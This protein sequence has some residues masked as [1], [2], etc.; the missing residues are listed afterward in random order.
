MARKTAKSAEDYIV[1]LLMNDLQGRML[2]MPPPR[3]KYREIMLVYGHHA[4]LERMFGLAEELNRYGGVTMPDLPGFGGMESFYKIKE[5]PTLD[6]LADYLAAFVKL[7]YR[8]RRLTVVAMSFGFMVVTRM[9]Q[10]YPE[11]AKRVDLLISIVGSVH[12]G[13]I[14]FRRHNYLLLRWAASLFSRRLPSALA[15]RLALRGPFIRLAYRL[16]EDR[17]SKLKDGTKRQ[18]RQ[19]IAFEVRL[20]QCNDFRTYAETGLSLLT[21]QLTDHHVALPVLH[22]YSKNDRYYDDLRVEQHMRQ[23]FS[24]FQAHPIRLPAHAPTVIASAKEAAPYIP[25]KIRALLRKKP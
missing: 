22:V 14:R 9:L 11:L 5:K 6:N 13:D 4:S 18:R 20:W 15:A 23:V 8:N 10:K 16:V 21:K 1:P 24:D 2:R 25:P 3:G 7:R 12:S 17:H 19:R